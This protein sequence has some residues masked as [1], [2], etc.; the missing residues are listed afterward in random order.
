MKSRTFEVAQRK[1]EPFSEL[2][3]TPDNYTI[4][5]MDGSNFTELVKQMDYDRPFDGE[6]HNHMVESTKYIV[7]EFQG[8][9]GATHSDEISILLP[10]EWQMFGR[11]QEKV[12]SLAAS[13]VSSV[14][15]IRSD[16]VANFD[17]RAYSYSTDEGVI[18]YF[19]WRLQD[20]VRNALTSICHHWI[21]K[22]DETA[23]GLIAAETLHNKNYDWKVDFLREKGIEFNTMPAWQKRGSGV[24]WEKFQKEAFNP[25]DK[26][27]VIA[28]R[29]RLVVNSELPLNGEHAKFI[30]KILDANR[31]K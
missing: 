5:R 8:I 2:R 16:T 13:L 27:N 9:Y 6:F 4:L 31:S 14:F 3:L 11:R 21:L 10:R 22:N 7:S 12:T 29:R 26:A 15:S 19:R 20:S 28:S 25:K 1:H 17:G 18:D 23:T 24:Y 30:Q